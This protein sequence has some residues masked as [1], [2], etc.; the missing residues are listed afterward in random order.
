MIKRILLGILVIFIIAFGYVYL[1]LFPQFPVAN[2][3]A[4]KKM[5]SC[6]FIADRS[7][8]SIQEDDL[9]FG[10]TG[11]THSV[12]DYEQKSITTSLFGMSPK[13][14]VYREGVGCIL[15]KGE[16]DYQTTLSLDRPALSDT[17]EWPLGTKVTKEDSLGSVDMEQLQAAIL[18]NFDPSM[19]MDSVKTRAIVVVHK[20]RLIAEQYAKGF[21]A[22]TEILG[23][24]M[25]KSIASTMVGVLAKNGLLKLE[26]TNLFP[27]WTDE[28][29][30]I[31]LKDLLQMQSGLEFNED[32][33][34]NSDATKMLYK[35][36]NV[37]EIPLNKPLK[38]EPGTHWSY[39]SG[40]TNL[41][42]RIVK[43]KLDEDA[44]LRLPYDSIF[45]RIGMT[46][47][48]METDESGLYI[49]SSYCYATPRDW[50][51]FGLLYLNQGNWYGD[52]VIDSSWVDFVRTPASDSKGIY[53]GQFW[54]NVNHS[55]Y[56][57]CPEEVYSCNGFQGQ[58]VI[59]VPS[60]DLV[61]VRM[62]LEEPP[63]FDTNKLLKEIL[64]CFSKE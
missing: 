8:E 45:N 41:L 34:R 21:D 12:I 49:G 11:L 58:R 48:V 37:S 23:W 7:Q 30:N 28:R 25:T 54:L 22:D 44:Y 6:T 20:G 57:D 35:S 15:L 9:G 10:P 32:Y 42:S 59:I 43:D 61:V 16:D 47:A 40:T 2:G 13:T 24:S 5:C 36:E 3:Y 14:A 1:M 50:A 19:D 53:G 46:S 29:K 31:S 52:Q 55:Q 26:D 33:T 64:D 51:K 39:S 38:Y 17:L 60:Y 4:A 62:G 63:V 18:N 27:Q 56:K